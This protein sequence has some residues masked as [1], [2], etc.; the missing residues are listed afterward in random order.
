L[1]LKLIQV[2]DQQTRLKLL[3]IELQASKIAEFRLKE[4]NYR[5][6]KSIELV[7]EAALKA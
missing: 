2:Q 5:L 7:S 4:T 3:E 6:L 1:K